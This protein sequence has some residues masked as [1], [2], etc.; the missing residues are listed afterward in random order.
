MILAAEEANAATVVNEFEELLLRIFVVTIMFG[1]GAGLTP[2]D[3][4]LALRRPWG[5]IIGWVTQFGIMPLVTYLLI[6]SVLLPS[7]DENGSSRLTI[8]S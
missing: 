8:F 1:L 3:F 5:L 4:G 2:K 7:T 6:I